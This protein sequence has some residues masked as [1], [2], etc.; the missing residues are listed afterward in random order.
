[1]DDLETMT[2]T[3]DDR[4]DAI[5]SRLD[6]LEAENER[7]QNENDQLQERVSDLED[8]NETLA[9]ENAELRQQVEKLPDIEMD[10]D[11]LSSLA[12][13]GLPVGR[14][15]S[16]SVTD[17]SLEAELEALKADLEAMNPTPEGGKTTGQQ[18]ETPIEQVVAMPESVVEDQLTANQERARFV[19]S[20][21][22]DYATK[23]QTGDYTLTASDL[24]SVLR[25]AYDTSHSETVDR[26]RTIIADLGGDEIEIQ[27]PR[28]AGFSPDTKEEKRRQGKKL[29]VSSSLVRRL[30]EIDHDVVTKAQT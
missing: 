19:A 9:K 8:H 29:V 12:V 5:E 21:I 25:A 20:S 30:A 23:V 14:K 11:D 26:V 6:D 28:T 7:L 18:H 1:M 17:H 10:G 15:V 13:N 27:E 22:T 16:A 2:E 24:R 3:T 4:L